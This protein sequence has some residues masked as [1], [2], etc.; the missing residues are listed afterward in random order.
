[1]VTSSGV[2]GAYGHSWVYGTGARAHSEG[3]A[4]LAARE[5][6]LDLNNHA[7]SGSLSTE[8][9]RLVTAQAPEPADVF[10]VMTGFNDARLYGAAPAGRRQYEDS[11]E[12]LFRALHKADPK[13]LLLAIEQP[14]VEDYSGHSPYD[15][16]TDTILDQ[17]NAV[18][19]AV[20]TALPFAATVVVDGWDA[21]TMIAP[22]NVHPND[23]GHAVLA[24][25]VVRAAREREQP[26]KDVR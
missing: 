9:A 8:T 25:A 3:F 1:M 13:A 18:L 23:D 21:R 2:L 17:Y 14:Y 19:R 4:V 26:R 7:A 12:V 20:V 6:G 22:D 16:A 5:L 11:L 24:R 15:R 10:V